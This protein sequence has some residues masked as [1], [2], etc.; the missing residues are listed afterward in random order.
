MTKLTL[1]EFTALEFYA[2][3]QY[4]ELYPDHALELQRAVSR[5]RIKAARENEVLTADDVEGRMWSEL[6]DSEK[7][8]LR[9]NDQEGAARLIR[10]QKDHDYRTRHKVALDAIFRR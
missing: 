1:E 2:R 3:T 8:K 9:Y 6:S 10:E 4:A 5:E 7:R